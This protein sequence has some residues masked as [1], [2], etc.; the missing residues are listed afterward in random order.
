[1]DMG[2]VFRVGLLIIMLGIFLCM[3]LVNV[4]MC[5]YYRYLGVEL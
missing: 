5:F 1:M 4:C 3:I 2:V